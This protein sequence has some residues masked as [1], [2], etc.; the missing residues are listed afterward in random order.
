MATKAKPYIEKKTETARTERMESP[1]LKALEKKQGMDRAPSVKMT[2]PAKTV[3]VGGTKMKSYR[4][5]G[6]LG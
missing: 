3:T 6:G 1:K 2:N 4:S 5:S